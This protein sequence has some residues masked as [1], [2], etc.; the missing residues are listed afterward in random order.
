VKLSVV[1]PCLNAAGTIEQQLDALEAQSWDGDWEIVVAENGSDDGTHAVLE[2]YRERLPRLRVVDASRR[3]GSAFAM[4]TGARE[5]QGEWIAFCDADDSVGDGWLTAVATALAEH[6]LVAYRQDDERLNAPWLRET[7]EKVFS[8][9][10]P[11]LW[12]PPHV[13]FTGA[14]CLAMHKRLFEEVD[15][16]DETLFLEDLDFC[17]RAQLHG[18]RI[19]LVPDAVLHY[20]YRDSYS[21]IFRQAYSYGEGMAAIQRRYKRPGARF[22]RQNRWLLTGWKP[23]L[24][25]VPRVLRRGHRAKLVWQLGWQLGR[26]RGSLKYRVLAV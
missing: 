23:L 18:A 17:I 12:F 20:R 7:R 11:T 19:E 14:G 9:S 5:A 21:G 13:P 16:F 3:R 8:Y 1:I 15:G 25:R 10:L 4:N 6:E 26:Y 2:S 24:W 22:P